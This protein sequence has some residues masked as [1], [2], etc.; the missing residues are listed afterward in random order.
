MQ[1]TDEQLLE[2]KSLGNIHITWKDYALMLIN[3]TGN[4]GGLRDIWR[5]KIMTSY[6]HWNQKDGSISEVNVNGL[7]VLSELPSEFTES[8]VDDH[9]ELDGQFSWRKLGRLSGSKRMKVFI[10]KYPQE[11]ISNEAYLCVK[12]ILQHWDEESHMIFES[13]LLTKIWKLAQMS[14]GQCITEDEV[15]TYLLERPIDDRRHGAWI[16][17]AVDVLL[18]GKPSEKYAEYWKTQPVEGFPLNAAN[19]DECLKVLSSMTFNPADPNYSMDALYDALY[20]FF[21]IYQCDLPI[22]QQR[23]N[24]DQ[25][26]RDKILK[27][28]INMSPCWKKIAV[29]VLKN[30]VSFK[31]AGFGATS[32]ERLA[33]EEAV[34]AFDTSQT[35]KEK[36]KEEA[37]RL[38]EQIRKEKDEEQ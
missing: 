19:K 34:A 35:E 36:A 21:D 4:N 32:R 7:E 24:M 22:E 13:P 23:M 30:D 10:G 18:N 27:E 31:Y 8:V 16:A 26:C 15:R 28:D 6:V 1:I 38:A 25:I 37:L 14:N 9:Y 33:R 12:H 5:E 29:C 3:S 2:L 17:A 11:S 20:L